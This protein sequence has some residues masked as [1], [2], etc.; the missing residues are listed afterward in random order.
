ML[1]ATLIA[2]SLAVAMPCYAQQVRVISRDIEHV[3]GAG[4]ELLDSADL[5]SRNQRAWE[6]MQAE[7]L[8]A[9]ERQQAGH[10]VESF[11]PQ[12]AL[13]VAG[14]GQGTPVPRMGMQNSNAL[15]ML[16]R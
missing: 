2:A 1:R 11:R 10:E 15:N 7:L 6:R 4:G 16:P 8:V 12:E 14:I 5:Q 3:Y 9:I 13:V